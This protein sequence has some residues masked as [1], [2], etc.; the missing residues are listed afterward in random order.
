M[1]DWLYEKGQTFVRKIETHLQK[2]GKTVVLEKK[3]R[4]EMM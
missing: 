1:I 3:V 4:G 2:N